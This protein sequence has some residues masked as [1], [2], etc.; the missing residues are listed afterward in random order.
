MV[1]SGIFPLYGSSGIIGKTSIPSY[2]ELLVLIA[3]VGSIGNIQYV[4]SPCGVSDN[5][6][7]VRAGN[8]SKLIY[9]YLCGYNFKQITSGTTQPL[10]TASDVKK[11]KIPIFTE[12]EEKKVIKFLDSLYTKIK[13]EK[14]F[15][16]LLNRQK[17]YLL[18][19][20]FI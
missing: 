10:I 18:R 11:I 17:N 1:G 7:V 15:M 12:S 9:Y 16:N 2:R 5:T 3:R 20:M 6:I 4:T 19:K 13:A 8:K 14:E